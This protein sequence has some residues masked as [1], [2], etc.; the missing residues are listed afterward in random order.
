MSEE[1]PESMPIAPSTDVGSARL[2]AA[3]AAVDVAAIGRA[4]RADYVVVPLMRGPG[5]ETQTR[6]IEAADPEG[7]RKWEL[8]LFSSTETYSAFLADNAEREFALQAGVGL[9]PLLDAYLPLLRR[10]VF[11]AAGPHPVQATPEDVRASLQPSPDDDAV[12]WITQEQ[13]ERGLREGERVVGFDLFLG[14]DWARID[15]TEPRHIERDVRALVKAQL[16]GVP[17]APVLRGQLTTWLTQT[18][19]TAAGGGGHLLAFLTRR[20]AEAAASVSVTQYWQELGPAGERSH[21]DAVG[22]R[23]STALGPQDQLHAAETGGTSF[24]RL[25]TRRMGPPELAGRPLGVVDYWLAFPDG[26]GLCLVS[27]STPHIE[28]LAEVRLL[29]DNVI[30]AAAWDVAPAAEGST[31]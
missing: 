24:L 8:H 22:E 17:S 12:A 26:R 20:T 18:A 30:L 9:I 23:L 31:A 19:R 5:G 21:L 13:A 28:Q 10:V 14:D 25:T 6:V 11:D 7:E 4:L 2:A 3:L 29:A 16:K 15:L 1:Q 27:F